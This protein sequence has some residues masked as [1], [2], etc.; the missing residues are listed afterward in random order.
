MIDQNF[1]EDGFVDMMI[2][3]TEVGY[4]LIVKS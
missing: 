2:I 4:I 1:S 3:D